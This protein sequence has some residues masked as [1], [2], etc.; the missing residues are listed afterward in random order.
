M[1]AVTIRHGG[2]GNPVA[3]VTA[4]YISS[5]DLPKNTATGYD[6]TKY[7]AS[8]AINYYFQAEL[9]GQ[10]DLRSQVFS[11][12]D[13]HGEWND[14]IFGAAGTWSVHCRAVADDSSVANLSV[15]VVAP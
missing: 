12:D 14:L 2:A 3:G 13:G 5:T 11:P 6:A 15:E 8:P 9:A 4:C 10:D 1:A 7:P